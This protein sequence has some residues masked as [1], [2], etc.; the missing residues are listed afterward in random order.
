M[1]MHLILYQVFAMVYSDSLVLKFFCGVHKCGN[2]MKI[3]AFQKTDFFDKFSVSLIPD[4][5]I[6][7]NIHHPFSGH[8]TTKN[9]FGQ[10]T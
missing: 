8:R 3:Y 7:Y 4:L 1:Y 6:C 9:L 10:R 5:N 2:F